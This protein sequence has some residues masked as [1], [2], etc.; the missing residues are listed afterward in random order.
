M[1]ERSVVRK[2]NFQCNE[3]YYLADEKEKNELEKTAASDL[4]LHGLDGVLE[5]GEEGGDTIL[6]VV[7]EHDGTIGVHGLSNVE[8]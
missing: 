4:D 2:E 7:E 6:A 3:V 1:E 5:D 8:L